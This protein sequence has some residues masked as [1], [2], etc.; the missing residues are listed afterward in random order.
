[1]MGSR[2]R[3]S[4]DTK[5]WSGRY[6]VAATIRSAT[7]A[8]A[9]SLTSIAP[10]GCGAGEE[11]FAGVEAHQDRHRVPAGG[12]EPVQPEPGDRGNPRLVPDVLLQGRQVGEGL[13]VFGGELPAGGELLGVG[14]DP[15]RVGEE[16][17]G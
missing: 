12:A 9:P 8:R 11:G 1:M 5:L 10:S 4:S 17:A 6:P 3:R 15:A 2:S 14:F 16:P 13:Q 7:T